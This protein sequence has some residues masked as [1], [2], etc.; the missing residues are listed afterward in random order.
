VALGLDPAT[1]KTRNP[2]QVLRAWDVS[3]LHPIAANKTEKLAGTEREAVWDKLFESL[4]DPDT[5]QANQV[6]LPFRAMFS[7]VLHGDD[8]VPWLR[9]RMG[10]PP[11]LSKVPGLIVDLDSDDFNK[12]EQ[13]SAE[14]ERLGEPTRSFLERALAKKPSAETK[15]RGEALLAK[16]QEHA[17]AYE[18]RQM[19][20]I[21]VL[22][23]ID[24]E[25]ARALLK[26][27]ADGSYDP[28]Y[29]GE[30]QQ[31]LQRAAAKR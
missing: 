3:A 29:A 19:R 23:H 26:Q 25:A 16:L 18:L 12:R 24:T 6:A 28:T 31:A 20:I 30:A 1:E 14:L 22:E 27:I 17:A 15:K 8:A 2:R 13:A 10:S 21:D 7:L 5:S 9:K 4:V 11:D